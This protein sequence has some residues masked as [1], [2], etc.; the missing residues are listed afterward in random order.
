MALFDVPGWTVAS[1]PI[2]DPATTTSKKRKR[3]VDHDEDK[4]PAAQINLDKLMDTLK[5]GGEG[6]R[7]K[8]KR[9]RQK[10]KKSDNETTKAVDDKQHKG[11]DRRQDA[12]L[13]KKKGERDAVPDHEKDSA[14]PKKLRERKRAKK[15]DPDAQVKPD[16]PTDA[17]DA[18][19]P[20]PGGLTTFQNRMKQSLDGARF[21]YVTSASLMNVN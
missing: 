1:E 10:G 17:A 7:E 6:T 8:S 16:V 15:S 3:P 18:D 13:Q 14:P 19:A 2:K 20:A 11:V 5:D 12:S 4:V 9:K 21:R